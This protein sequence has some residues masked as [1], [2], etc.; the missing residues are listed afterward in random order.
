[1]HLGGHTGD[2]GGPCDLAKW[3]FIL[4]LT[5]VSLSLVEQQHTA[6]HGG[7]C[8]GLGE[9]Q[10][11]PG[12]FWALPDLSG[13]VFMGPVPYLFALKCK[14]SLSQPVFSWACVVAEG[15]P[16]CLSWGSSTLLE[17]TGQEGG[18]A[19]HCGG[20]FLVQWVPGWQADRGEGLLPASRKHWVNQCA[21][22]DL[23]LIPCSS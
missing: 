4:W 1:M 3:S 9:L 7:G 14:L 8:R 19:R 21:G 23:R 6:P 15:S 17:E 2:A 10:L 12:K 22:Q 5:P 16:M 20:S 11:C 18:R 13:C